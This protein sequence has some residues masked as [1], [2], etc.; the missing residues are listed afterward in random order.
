MRLEFIFDKE[1]PQ[2]I[3][4][5][6]KE[7]GVSKALLARAKFQGGKIL[8][9]DEVKNVLH[10]L[11]KGERLTLI[12][13]PE[14]SK[15][16]VEKEH[17]PLD[18]VYE[19]EYLMIINKP[20]DIPSIPVRMYPT[21]TMVNRVA[22]YFYRQ[23]YEDQ[24]VHTVTRLDKDTSGLMIFAKNSF[25]HA[26]LDQALRSKQI[27]K[28][29]KAIVHD[30]HHQLKKHEVIEAPIAR[31]EGSTMEREVCSDGK[32]A[33]TEYWL[34][35]RMNDQ[36]LVDIL[37]HTGRTHQIRVHFTSLHCPL[38]GDTLYGGDRQNIQRQ[39][40]HCYYLSF[41]HPVTD[42]SLSF[43]IPI[44]DDMKRCLE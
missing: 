5:F 9:N 2:K 32:Y 36:A 38:L 16:T 22:G 33:K 39:A 11:T 19:D 7:Q 17:A 28:K 24:V 30:Y 42:E 43:E 18:I 44:A 3:K 40:L 37:L 21:G 1:Q 25:A 6:V 27:I 20:W 14:V 4:E 10:L 15:E 12:F 29:Y 35:E 31:K 41:K 23:G 8:V 34:L 26:K 13:P